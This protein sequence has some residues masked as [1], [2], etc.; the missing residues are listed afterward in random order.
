ME[1]AQQRVLAKFVDGP[2]CVAL[3]NVQ[4]KVNRLA[5]NQLE[6]VIWFFSPF[7]E[8]QTITNQM[9]VTLDWTS[10]A[11]SP[12]QELDELLDKFLNS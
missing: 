8:A 7:L 2:C 1:C 4:A 5:A 9:E 11:A 6:E 10:L 3:A 12:T